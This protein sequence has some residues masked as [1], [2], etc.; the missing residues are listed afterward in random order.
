MHSFRATPYATSR[1]SKGELYKSF[2]VVC[3]KYGRMDLLQADTYTHAKKMATD[4]QAAKELMFKKFRKSGFSRWV[5]KP[6]EE[7]MFS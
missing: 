1:V 6:V 3:Q 7:G 2:K 4:F 5:E